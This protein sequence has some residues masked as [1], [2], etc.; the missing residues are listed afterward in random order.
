VIGGVL[1]GVLYV[2]SVLV[3]IVVTVVIQAGALV[4]LLVSWPPRPA[5]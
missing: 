3:L 4:L 1:A 5:R 2:S